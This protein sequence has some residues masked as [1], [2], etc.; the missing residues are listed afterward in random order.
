MID[1]EAIRNILTLRYNPHGPTSLPKLSSEDLL[2]YN[3]QTKTFH[4][5][6]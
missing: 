5:R 4:A 3:S 2:K 6:L 1:N